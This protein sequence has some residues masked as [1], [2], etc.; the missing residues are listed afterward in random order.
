MG[1]RSMPRIEAEGYASTASMTQ[2]PVTG[3]EVKD[4]LWGRDRSDVET[5]GKED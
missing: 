1:K 5:L 4:T 2:I 3:T